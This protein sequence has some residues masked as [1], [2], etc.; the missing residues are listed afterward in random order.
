MT[1]MVPPAFERDDEQKVMLGFGDE[2]SAVAAF[3]QHFD[4]PRFFGGVQAMPVAE[5]RRKV[6]AADGA[7]MKSCPAVV[8]F[9]ARGWWGS[10]HGGSHIK[11]MPHREESRSI[12]VGYD[13]A[14]KS[15]H[16]G[17]LDLLTLVKPSD[18]DAVAVSR[19]GWKGLGD[20]EVKGSG[21]GLVKFIWRHGEMSKKPPELQVTREDIM[22]FPRVIRAYEPSRDARPGSPGREWR[23]VRNNPDYG[24]RV[25]VYA[26][27]LMDGGR[28][29]VSVFVQESE[30][31][32]ADVPL[33]KKKADASAESPSKRLEA[34]T[35]DTTTGFLHQPG[36][37]ASA[38]PTIPNPG[39]ESTH[40]SLPA[41]GAFTQE[42]HMK[43]IDLLKS[44]IDAYTRS[45]G[46]VVQAHE[47]SRQKTTF[48]AMPGKLNEHRADLKKQ[49]YQDVD[50]QHIADGVHVDADKADHHHYFMQH[51]DG[52][53]AVVFS[54]RNGNHRDVGVKHGGGLPEGKGSRWV[55]NSFDSQ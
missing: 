41:G 31:P 37:S 44:H 40:K 30:K 1:T 7:M 14:L 19:G 46:T 36:Q 29:L 43:K 27:S 6:R 26:D 16:G 45:D 48:D 5:F 24:D 53:K 13:A 49:G 33:S 12:G 18:M 21:F 9:K 28:H 8:F 20:I 32:G 38:D 15:P 47:D 4:D 55:S 25:V 11:R 34:H 39:E 22:D 42:H 23:V 54:H 52:R 10:A 2:V 3:L 50:E 51:P 35:G 17:K